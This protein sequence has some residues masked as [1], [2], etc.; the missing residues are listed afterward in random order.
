MNKFYYYVAVGLTIVNLFEIAIRK[1]T[2]FESILPKPF[3]IISIA[4]ALLFFGIH[5]YKNE[6]KKN[7]NVNRLFFIVFI[8]F[9]Y[10]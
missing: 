9:C 4:I 7:S 10:I 3:K 6:N 5:F 1:F 8:A 2:N